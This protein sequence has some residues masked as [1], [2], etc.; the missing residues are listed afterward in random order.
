MINY[1]GELTPDAT[2]LFN[3]TNRGF[4]FGDALFEEIRIVR[5]QPLF[6][7]A[8]YFRLM[9]SMRMLR[10]EIPMN[11]TLEYFQEQLTKTI[12]A[13]AW[14]ALSVLA[15]ISVFRHGGTVI[16]EVGD[17]VTFLI[18]G[19]VLESPFYTL[20]TNPYRVELYKDFFVNADLLS[21]L[22]ISDQLLPALA[23]IYAKENGYQDCLLLNGAKSVVATIYGNLFLVNGNRVK[24]P[25]VQDGCRNG[26]MRKTLVE[27][28]QGTDSLE[29]HEESIS[30]FEL[31]KANE[32][33]VVNVKH[34]ILPITQYRKK[35]YSA[36]VA[37]QLLG[38]L[39]AHV[40]LVN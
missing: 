36:E 30:P 16:D 33:F 5:Q 27:I 11:F 25:P 35:K 22:D 1:N 32:L 28:I 34:G 3:H 10:M 40:R 37:G 38:K 4:R 31:Q 29:L 8:H 39:N 2:P 24:T 19:T 14:Q 20:P 17:K 12:V 15:R 23:S 21:S 26:I 6:L 18:D 9:A 13:N 7:E